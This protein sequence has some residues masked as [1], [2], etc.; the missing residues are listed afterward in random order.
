MQYRLRRH[1]GEY[2][3]ISDNGVPRYDAQENFT[4]YIGSCLDV[5][6]LLGKERALRESEERMSLVMDA[7]NLGSW[8]WDADE[9]EIWGTINAP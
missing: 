9:D 1:D 6:E 3:W 5:T 8:E 2:R 7:A 4:G